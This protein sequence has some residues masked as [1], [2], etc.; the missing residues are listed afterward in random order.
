MNLCPEKGR[1]FLMLAHIAIELR[2]SP[3]TPEQSSFH[4]ISLYSDL[5][6]AIL[7]V[8]WVNDNSFLFEIRGMLAN[9]H[10][11]PYLLHLLVFILY[12]VLFYTELG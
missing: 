3:L 9:L 8:K 2:F 6:S 12:V 4:Y 11:G 1:D 10:N 7:P 5:T